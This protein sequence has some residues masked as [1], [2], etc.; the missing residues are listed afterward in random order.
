MLIKIKAIIRLIFTN[1][2]LLVTVPKTGRTTQYY[3][4]SFGRMGKLIESVSAFK[5]DLLNEFK[6]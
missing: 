3:N 6:E 4:I 1:Q 5:E 2:Y